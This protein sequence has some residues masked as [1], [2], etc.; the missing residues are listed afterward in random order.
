MQDLIKIF[1]SKEFGKMEV[2]MI[3]NKPFFPAIDLRYCL[4]TAKLI[5]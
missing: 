2:L 3:D 5:M 4:A 1:E